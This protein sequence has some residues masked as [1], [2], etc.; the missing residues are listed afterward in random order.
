LAKTE[1]E[2]LKLAELSTREAVFEA[3]RMYVPGP[4]PLETTIAY[5]S[6]L[7]ASISFTMTRRTRISSLSFRGLALKPVGYICQCRRS[8][9]R[10]QIQ[11]PATH[12]TQTWW[13]KTNVMVVDT[14]KP[15][16]QSYHPRSAVTDQTARPQPSTSPLVQELKIDHCLNPSQ[17]HFILLARA[18]GNWAALEPWLTSKSN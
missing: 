9:T 7:K 13:I 18:L 10:R 14:L 15:L 12:L 6:A 4:C 16:H 1:L 11:R 8:Y 2:K 5:A 3:A 17:S